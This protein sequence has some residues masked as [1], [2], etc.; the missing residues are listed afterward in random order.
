MDA[1][2]INVYE[3]GPNVRALCRCTPASFSLRSTCTF[4][5]SYLLCTECFPQKN[6]LFA[7]IGEEFAVLH[8]KPLGVLILGYLPLIHLA[9]FIKKTHAT[10]FPVRKVVVSPPADDLLDQASAR[11]LSQRAPVIPL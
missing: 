1:Y 11:Q 2:V 8:A 9:A 10:L 5:S 4:N 3:K 7:H 6:N